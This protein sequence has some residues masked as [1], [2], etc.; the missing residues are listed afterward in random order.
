M[1]T[2]TS[3]TVELQGRI[4][5]DLFNQEKLILNG[6][7]LTL[8]LHRHKPEFCFLSA[9]VAPAYKIIIVDAILYVKKIELT[10]SVFNA[11]NTVLNDKN[12]QYAITRTTPKV[13]TVPR[14]QQSQHIDN[15]FLGEIPKRISVCM[16]DNDSY[17]GTYKKNPF[18]F[19]HY[20]LTQIGI[21][22][23][24]EE[25]PFKPLKLNFDDKLFVTAYNTLFSG[26]G[27]LHGNSGSIIKREDYSE[28]YTIIVADL[29]P[30]EIGDNFDLK[31]EGTLSIDLVFKSPL[32]ATINVL[33]YAEYDNVIEIDSNHNAIKDW[34][35]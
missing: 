35:N 15:A 16:M 14:G 25:V 5:S 29:T 28:G 30:F 33:V 26:T 4:H 31:A 18:N 10:P 3:K 6:V 7:D 21:S 11:I 19:Q 9:D 17:N 24:G 32:A 2:K 34:S 12:A 8:K 13:F 27:K 20:N 23:N 1:W 22:V